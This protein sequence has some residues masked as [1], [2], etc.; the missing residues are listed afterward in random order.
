MYEVK[1][2]PLSPEWLVMDAEG[3]VLCRIHN[4]DHNYSDTPDEA[5]KEAAEMICKALNKLK[6]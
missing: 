2:N 4:N 5:A 6:P 1:E 3:E